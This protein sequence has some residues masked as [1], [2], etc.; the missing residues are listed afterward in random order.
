MLKLIVYIQYTNCHISFYSYLIIKIYFYSSF[1][2]WEIPKSGDF[3]CESHYFCG[4][5][6]ENNIKYCFITL[7]KTDFLINCARRALSF[8]VLFL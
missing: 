4:P 6:I 8:V 2:C 1:S 7:E 5:I 3:S